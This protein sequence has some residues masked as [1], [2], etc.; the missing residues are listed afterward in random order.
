MWKEQPW[1]MGRNIQVIPNI[2]LR[3]VS[4]NCRFHS[5]QLYWIWLWS[6]PMACLAF[7]CFLRFDMPCN[8]TCCYCYC[9]CSP[10]SPTLALASCFPEF[11]IQSKSNL[12]IW[13]N[14]LAML[15]LRFSISW[16]LR[17]DSMD[18]FSKTTLEHI[19]L[20]QPWSQYGKCLKTE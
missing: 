8:C 2:I 3:H 19:R 17:K 10:P 1:A 14:L 18:I 4:C 11:W 7:S 6:F 16:L 13:T 15:S 9:S 20:M 5:T 12:I